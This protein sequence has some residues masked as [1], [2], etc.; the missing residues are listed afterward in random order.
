MVG[1]FY[2]RQLVCSFSL[3][4]ALALFSTRL[5]SFQISPR[6]FQP[7]SSSLTVSFR[8][9]RHS[10][11]QHDPGPSS[12]PEFCVGQHSAAADGRQPAGSPADAHGRRLRPPEVAVRA[13]CQRAARDDDAGERVYRGLARHP[14]GFRLVRPGR[15]P[16]REG[17]RADQ[18]GS[19]GG[20]EE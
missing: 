18:G 2:L 11:H 13:R 14:H 12:A 6:T 3:K 16:W 9:N 15:A 7:H 8:S 5:S 17:K 1:S 4:P 19:A 20:E 10:S